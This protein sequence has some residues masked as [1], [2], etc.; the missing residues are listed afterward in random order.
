MSGVAVLKS[1]REPSAAANTCVGQQE[2]NKELVGRFLEQGARRYMIKTF[3]FMELQRESA[4]F[5]GA[6]IAPREFIEGWDL[7]I[8]REEHW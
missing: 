4:V 7:T 3:S 6:I 1:F 2:T 8:N 5:C